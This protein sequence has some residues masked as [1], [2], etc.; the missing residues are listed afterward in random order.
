LGATQMIDGDACI[1][2]LHPRPCRFKRSFKSPRSTS[3]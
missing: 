2:Q 3:T 1:Q